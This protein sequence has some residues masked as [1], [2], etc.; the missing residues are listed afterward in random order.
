MEANLFGHIT[1]RREE[2]DQEFTEVIGTNTV[3]VVLSF[4]TRFD[5]PGD[6]EQCQVMADRGLTLTQPGA[7]V[8]HVEFVVLGQVEQDPES[9]LV[10]EKL[11]NLRQLTD[12]LLGNR[13]HHRQ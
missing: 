4:P 6:P 5:Q 9:G 13:G 2:A 3:E 8:G 7:E 12:G 11:E 1:G 10:A